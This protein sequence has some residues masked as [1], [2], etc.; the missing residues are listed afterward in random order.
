MRAVN[1]DPLFS[2]RVKID[3]AKKHLEHLQDEVSA[4]WAGNPYVIIFD[5]DTE[6][7]KRLYRI[8][9]TN[10]VP[11]HWGGYVGDVVHNLRASLDNLATALA[12]ANG[13][14]SK[15]VLRK[16]YFPIGATKEIFEKKLPEDL[17]GVRADARRIVE[18]MKPYP[19]GTDAFRRLHDLDVLDKHSA[20]VPVGAANQSVVWR[21]TMQLPGRKPFE[22]PIGFVHAKP[23]YP[24]KDGDVIFSEP[25]QEQG[26]FTF[27][28]NVAFG[29]G[30]IADG[31]PLVPTPK[32]F[33]DFVESVVDVFDREFFQPVTVRN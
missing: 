21:P 25:S 24:L 26:N 32:Q 29:E 28:F 15:S 31:E 33:I 2:V 5:T 6:P 23:F 17:R 11:G 14:T 10:D 4:F 30:Q 7:G 9:I 16:T 8:K 1:T 12:A 22:V 18:R 27:S 13:T 3:R 20:L 19:G